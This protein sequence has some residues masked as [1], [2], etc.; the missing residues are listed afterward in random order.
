MV[1]LS[2]RYRTVVIGVFALLLVVTSP[3]EVAAEWGQHWGTMV[4][5]DSA[6]DVP[7][8]TD[9]IS[10]FELHPNVPNPFNPGTTIKY[11]LSEPAQVSLRVYSLSGKLVRVLESSVQR[12]AGHFEMYWNGK[13]ETGRSVASG[14]YTYLL[15]VGSDRVH[16]SMVL[17]K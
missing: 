6:L 15:D 8:M 4:W 2:R 17:L 16:R 5:G 3:L 14:I 13:D 12:Q 7:Q 1:Q 10:G 11:S 9:P